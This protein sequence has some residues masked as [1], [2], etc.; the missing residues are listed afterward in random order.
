MAK[1][2]ISDIKSDLEDYNKWSE[3]NK[4]NRFSLFDYLHAI[5]TQR[6][7]KSD[8]IV[9]LVSFLWPEFYELEKQVF[10]AETFSEE[11]YNQIKDVDRIKDAEYFINSYSICETFPQ[12][13]YKTLKIIGDIIAESWKAKLKLDFPHMDFIVECY[14]DDPEELWCCFYQKNKM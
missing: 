5:S 13:E 9:S 10:L 3:A 1:E 6:D 12:I 11:R 14:E 8:F 4:H 7:I 2:L